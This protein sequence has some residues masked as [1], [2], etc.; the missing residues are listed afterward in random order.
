MPDRQ[1]VQLPSDLRFLLSVFCFPQPPAIRPIRPI[2]PKR[3]IRPMPAKPPKNKLQIHVLTKFTL[4]ISP[5]VL[6]HTRSESARSVV[7]VGF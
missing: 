3:P 5:P 1:T 4:D 6:C 7:W 2:R